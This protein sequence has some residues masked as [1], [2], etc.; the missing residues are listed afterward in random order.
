[1]LR[2]S[3]L[4]LVIALLSCSLVAQ[5]NSAPK[6]SVPTDIYQR[7]LNEDVAYIIAPEERAAY[8][9]LT[10][11]D[12]RDHFIV[13]FWLRRDPT[14][15]TS[16]NE[17]KEEHYRRIAYSNANLADSR[18]GW[19]TDRGRIYILY[20][21]PDEIRAL[22][23]EVNGGPKHP[24]QVWKYNPGKE[25]RFIDNCNCGTYELDNAYEKSLWPDQKS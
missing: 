5:D 17:F 21:P 13:Q 22:P 3:A 14:P 23:A 25:F 19:K 11:K 1:M 7:W 9:R 16:E 18:P 2:F 24:T 20:G 6:T 12:E 8:L 10:T 4:L 15:G